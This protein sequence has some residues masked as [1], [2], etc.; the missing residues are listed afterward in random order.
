MAEH[1]GR[2]IPLGPQWL[3]SLMRLG[4]AVVFIYAGAV[5]LADPASFAEVIARYGILPR[6][7]VP[8][9]ALGLPALEVAAGVGLVLEAAGALSLI[10]AML[11]MFIGVLWFGVLQGLDVDCGCFAAEELA[12]HDSLRTALR[13]DLVMLAAAAYI[14]LWRWANRRHRSRR[15][16]LGLRY[17]WNPQHL[18][19][20]L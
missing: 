20:E 5:K 6:G 3:Y 1:P 4:L 18:S 15:G 19:E 2:P 8:W 12:E 7:L 9:A 16:P 13:R 10:T 14:Y 11:A 17:S